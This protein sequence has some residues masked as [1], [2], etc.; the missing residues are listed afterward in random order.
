[1]QVKVNFFKCMYVI[2]RNFTKIWKCYFW[3][4]QKIP[5]VDIVFYKIFHFLSEMICKYVNCW[6]CESK[7]IHVRRHAHFF[8]AVLFG[9]GIIMIWLK[10]KQRY[11]TKARNNLIGHQAIV[12]KMKKTIHYNVKNILKSHLNLKTW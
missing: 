6:L 10:I 11:N 12:L 1:M 3:I 4:R 9:S 2:W 7:N 8:Q 5:I